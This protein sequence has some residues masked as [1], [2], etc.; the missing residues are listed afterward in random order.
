MISERKNYRLRD[1]LLSKTDFDILNEIA[2]GLGLKN[3]DLA[4]LLL[5]QSLTDIKRQGLQNY[6][7]AIVGTLRRQKSA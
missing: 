5:K 6:K 7:L 4:R 1:L 3:T 2:V